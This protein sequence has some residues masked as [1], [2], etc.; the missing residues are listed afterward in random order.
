MSNYKPNVID[1]VPKWLAILVGG[2]GA[3]IGF[4]QPLWVGILY[5]VVIVSVGFVWM[6]LRESAKN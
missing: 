3:V 5:V 1:S 4:T 2:I 6:K